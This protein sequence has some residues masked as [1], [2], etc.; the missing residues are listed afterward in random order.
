MLS[1]TQIIAEV[2]D[3]SNF[4]KKYTCIL[5]SCIILELFQM[6]EV[7]VS[8]VLNCLSYIYIIDIL[9]VKQYIMVVHVLSQEQSVWLIRTRINH[10]KLF[11]CLII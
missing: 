2:Q 1:I 8:P 4:S 6:S 10:F 5:W 9:S 3:G 7:K 11:L